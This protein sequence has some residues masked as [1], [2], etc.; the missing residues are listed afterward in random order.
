MTAEPTN[1]MNV[2]TGL[3]DAEVA[4]LAA[5]AIAV[6]L[7]DK[8]ARKPENEARLKLLGDAFLSENEETR[9]AV[10]TQMRRDGIPVVKIIDWV[11]PE[12]ARQAGRRWAEDEISFADVT[13]ISA[14]L[15]ETV[16]ALG[17]GARADR[18]RRRHDT[19][20]SMAARPRILLIIPRPEQHTL[21]TFVAAD[22]L[23]RRGYAVDIALDLHPRQVAE[24]VRKTQYCMV[25]LTASGRRTL[26][27]ARDLV[28]T[29]KASVT[30]VTPTVL[31]GSIVASC[32]GLREKTGVDHVV[33][34]VDG[35]LR[36]CGLPD[37]T[38]GAARRAPGRD[39][40]GT[41]RPAEVNA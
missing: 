20:E 12:V 33:R 6:L 19:K 2:A 26:A 13:I 14:R 16:R 29:I 11:L 18:A 10:L 21:G 5:R 30:R 4:R 3:S 31:G 36:A 15:Q 41:G 35:A 9:H 32:R 28:E 24:K 27:S 8:D 40:M 22:Q 7:S 39:R 37:W 38:D 23:R 34:D 1:Q 17:G 25:G